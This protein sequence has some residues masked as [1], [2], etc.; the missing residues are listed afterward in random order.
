MRKPPYS[1]KERM[2]ELLK[3]LER[4]LKKGLK[5]SAKGCFTS[6]NRIFLHMI[7]H[8]ETLQESLAS[9]RIKP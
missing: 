8:L 3:D 4:I 6:H 5:L 7:S 9:E 2:A 1:E